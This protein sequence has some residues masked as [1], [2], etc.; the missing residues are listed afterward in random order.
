MHLFNIKRSSLEN[1]KKILH[2]LK[3]QKTDLTESHERN[4]KLVGKIESN[5]RKC[6]ETLKKK[7]NDMKR[8]RGQEKTHLSQTNQNQ[9]SVSTNTKHNPLSSFSSS[10]LSTKN[11]NTENTIKTRISNIDLESKSPHSELTKGNFPRPPSQNS[12]NHT[13]IT[14]KTKDFHHQ[15]AQIRRESFLQ[16]IKKH[17]GVSIDP[18]IE[19]RCHVGTLLPCVSSASVLDSIIKSQY[20]ESLELHNGE[21]SNVSQRKRRGEIYLI[22]SCLD[23]YALLYRWHSPGERIVLPWE[24]MDTRAGSNNSDDLNPQM[25]HTPDVLESVD[26][27]HQSQE[28]ERGNSI[29]VSK[30]K[31]FDPNAVLCPFELSGTC[32]DLNC[33]Y[34]HIDNE[35][36][37]RKSLKDDTWIDNL[38][39]PQLPLEINIPRPS[40]FISE[41]GTDKREITKK[42]EF[43]DEKIKARPRTMMELS[44][45]IHGARKKRKLSPNLKQ[46]I[47]SMTSTNVHS[48]TSLGTDQSEDERWMGEERNFILVPAARISQTSLDNEGHGHESVEKPRILSND[49]FWWWD[50]LQSQRRDFNSSSLYMPTDLLTLFSKCGFVINV[51][52]HNKSTCIDFKYSIEGG[53]EGE[54]KIIQLTAALVDCIRLS[55]FGG[56]FDLAFAFLELGK[57]VLE[58]EENRNVRED[59]LKTS[60]SDSNA[61]SNETRKVRLLSL[62]HQTLSSVEG[63][64][65][66]SMSSTAT[67]MFCYQGAFALL[68]EALFSF[69]SMLF[70]PNKTKNNNVIS[71]CTNDSKQNDFF[72][73]A[74]NVQ[75]WKLKLEKCS[76]LVGRNY[77]IQSTE[78][79]NQ[80]FVREALN[81][82]KTEDIIADITKQ[83]RNTIASKTHA[84]A[85]NVQTGSLISSFHTNTVNDFDISNTDT[86]RLNQLLKCVSIGSQLAKALSLLSKEAGKTSRNENSFPLTLVGQFVEQI[87]NEIDIFYSSRDFVTSK[88][89][90]NAFGSLCSIFLFAPIFFTY[91]DITLA[92]AKY[93]TSLEE[94]H[95]EIDFFR[96]DYKFYASLSKLDNLLH[97]V[98]KRIHLQSMI[99]SN[100]TGIEINDFE[101]NRCVLNELLIAPLISISIT[102]SVL[103]RMPNKAHTRIE[104]AFLSFSVADKK[105]RDES[106]IMMLSELLWSQLLCLYSSFPMPKTQSKDYQKSV[107]LIS[108][109]ANTLSE[110]SIFLS[111][112]NFPGD[113]D[114]MRQFY[115]NK[116]DSIVK[117]AYNAGS[118]IKLGKSGVAEKLDL[119]LSDVPLRMS[120]ILPFSVLSLSEKL[121][122]LSVSNCHLS[123]LPETFGV[124]MTRLEVRMQDS[125]LTSLVIVLRFSYVRFGSKVLVPHEL[126][127]ACITRF[128]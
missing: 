95:S 55:T 88:S 99:T 26:D 5:L 19:K 112:L 80:F 38:V 20:H 79:Y 23:P 43:T 83:F 8:E 120:N 6:L 33:T 70:Q 102:T 103:L 62:L 61:L 3:E 58:N 94:T 30:T 4:A 114:L 45:G 15:L 107:A 116:E 14:V 125:S 92:S 110:Y 127:I 89:Y 74:E 46:S 56:R 16:E 82:K 2:S 54:K 81:D 9:S 29:N 97:R 67:E 76:S 86:D 32:L 50:S 44:P 64:M 77:E 31:K 40:S 49:L 111:H 28:T 13:T 123:F 84:N 105:N 48:T 93:Q 91:L 34:Q 113:S 39:L 11:Q 7:M 124:Q 18:K 109:L 71:D 101:S 21:H 52:E 128:V 104:R 10:K 42:I 25:S 68:S 75:Q 57:K 59:E 60:K 122:K 73:S 72:L 65:R 96:L 69:Y 118:V 51:N 90:S 1:R 66:T 121:V 41:V 27:R 36:R 53:Q 24:W 47:N 87:W 85:N 119:S 22:G 106:G 100:K 115:C 78:E 17:P 117:K 98:I 126:F 108:N 63:I 35:S 37:H 12:L